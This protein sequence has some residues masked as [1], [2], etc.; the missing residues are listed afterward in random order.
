MIRKNLYD[1]LESLMPAG[2]QFINPYNNVAPIPP[3]G[4]DWGTFNV[5]NI[6]D[7]GWS[8]ERQTGYDETTGLITVDYDVQRIYTVRIEFY[9]PNAFNN[10]VVYKQQLQV[11]LATETGL[12]DL[13]TISDI[14]N[15]TFLQEDKN[16]LPRYNFD[17]DLYI[18]D[19]ITKTSPAIETATTEIHHYN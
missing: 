1:Y 12:A 4:T 19:T 11:G 8:Q 16:Y 14:R 15:L 18:V 5:I 7:R 2:V 9:G 6:A 3:P 10:I 13:K 17:A